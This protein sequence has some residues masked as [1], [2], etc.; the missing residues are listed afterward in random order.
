MSIEGCNRCHRFVDTDFEEVE[1]IDGVPV[2]EWCLTDDE[3]DKL[4]ES[5][6][7]QTRKN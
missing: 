3:Q 2:C 1:Y 5:D 6:N 7:D 4:L